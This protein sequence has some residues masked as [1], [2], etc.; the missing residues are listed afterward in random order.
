MKRRDHEHERYICAIFVDSFGFRIEIYVIEMNCTFEL[1][2][3]RQR[4]RRMTFVPD[5]HISNL[6]FTVCASLCA[7]LTIDKR[8]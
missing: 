8:K 2:Q 7:R 3:Q 5:A 1:Q 6:V 4:R